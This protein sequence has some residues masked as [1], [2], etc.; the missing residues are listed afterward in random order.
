MAASFDEF[1]P[2]TEKV[3]IGSEHVLEVCELVAGKRDKVFTVIFGDIDIIGAFNAF[4]KITDEDT[5]DQGVKDLA[6][7]A[8]K[9]LGGALTR[10]AKI[11]LSTE[12]NMK[13]TGCKNVTDFEKW[14]SNN[15]T[16]KQESKLLELVLD[17]NDF[18]GLIKNYAALAGKVTPTGETKAPELVPT[19]A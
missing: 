7:I 19:S 8:Q 14:V 5:K 18:V 2:K 6:G 1:M 9:V 15:M 16:M 3:L 12:A 17:V 13:K 10:I 4:T 11:V